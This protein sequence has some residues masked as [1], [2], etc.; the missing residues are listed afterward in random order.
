MRDV[1]GVLQ[2]MYQALYTVRQ[3]IKEYEVSN[4]SFWLVLH[5]AHCSPLDRLDAVGLVASKPVA[6]FC[7]PILPVLEDK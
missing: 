3:S 2:S 7:R 6:G 1:A 5:T 4:L